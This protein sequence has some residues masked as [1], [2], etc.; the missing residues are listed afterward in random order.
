MLRGPL[1]AVLT[2]AGL[3][4]GLALMAPGAMA[5]DQNADKPA[6]V[7]STPFEALV[8]G[9]QKYRAGDMKAAVDALELAAQGGEPLAQW[10]LGRMYADGDGVAENDSKA[11][12]IFRK[13]ANDHADDN[14]QGRYS[15][16]VANAFVSLGNYYL[17]GIPDTVQPNNDQAIRLFRY[18][19]MYFGDPEAQY[20]L[21]RVYLDPDQP[22]ADPHK[23]ARW[24][25][26]AAEKNHV[27]SQALLGQLMWMGD[28]IARRPVT[29]L[30][31]L[32][33]ALDH[34]DP[35]QA[36]WIKPLVDEAAAQASELTMTRAQ[37]RLDAWRKS[38]G[39]VI[40]TSATT[41]ANG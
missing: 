32:M 24:L 22:S 28:L 20:R 2:T 38:H 34:A 11:F 17:V 4:A 15:R 33:I 16:A 29:G 40:D 21:A 27:E 6:S 19:A 18:A 26:L 12:E 39:I 14:P 3:L 8:I 41:A 1:T 25:N 37:E 7:E 9:T 30:S 36:K 13:L 5:F 31:W 23:A 35:F 10:K